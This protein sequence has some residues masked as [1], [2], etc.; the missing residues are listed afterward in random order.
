MI[1]QFDILAI[2]EH[3]LLKSGLVFLSL[4]LTILITFMQSVRVII[5][6]LLVEKKRMEELHSFGTIPLMIILLL[7]KTLNAIA[8]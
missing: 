8:L 2:S 5:P 6:A 1:S 3:S 7:L 4:P